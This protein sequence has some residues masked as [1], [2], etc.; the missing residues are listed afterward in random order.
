MLRKYFNKEEGNQIRY[1]LVARIPGSHPGGSG[2]IPG[3]GKF[4][5]NFIH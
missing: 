4:F 5:F 1:G 3:T 2:S